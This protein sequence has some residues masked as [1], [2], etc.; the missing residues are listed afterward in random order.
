MYY[1]KPTIIILFVI[2]S[3]FLPMMGVL[4]YQQKISLINS[5]NCSTSFISENGY[6]VTDVSCYISKHE[7]KREI[8]IRYNEEH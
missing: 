6:T 8:V 7:T 3:I 5:N 1:T 4:F 2:I